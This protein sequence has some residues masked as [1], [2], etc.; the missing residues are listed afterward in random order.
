MKIWYKA[1]E[2]PALFIV[3]HVFLQFF[4]FM[5]IYWTSIIN[6]NLA[7]ILKRIIFPRMITYG[8]LALKQ[9]QPINPRTLAVEYQYPIFRGEELFMKILK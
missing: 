7:E 9:I 4:L 6:H 8:I 1:G 3:W 5:I 2:H